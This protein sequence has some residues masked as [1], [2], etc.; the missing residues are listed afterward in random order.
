MSRSSVD[1][2]HF[3]V[4][5]LDTSVL[6]IEHVVICDRRVVGLGL[7]CSASA[8]GPARFTSRGGHP[9]RLRMLGGHGFL[10]GPATLETIVGQAAHDD[11]VMWHVRLRIRVAR[12][13]SGGATS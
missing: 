10:A 5:G 1:A 7:G 13:R 4:Q 11:G 2:P 3:D 6:G 9:A 8:P 12:P